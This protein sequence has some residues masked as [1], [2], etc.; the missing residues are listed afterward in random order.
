MEATAVSIYAL[1]AYIYKVMCRGSQQ[2]HE[3]SMRR[4][5]RRRKK[6][7]KF[8]ECILCSNGISMEVCV[9]VESEPGVVG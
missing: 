1:G 2:I 6:A 7:K 4:K 9:D 5:R 3:H 8:N